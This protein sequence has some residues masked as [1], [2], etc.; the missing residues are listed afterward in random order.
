[1]YNAP[2]TCVVTVHGVGF[3][4]PPSAGRAGYADQ[5]HAGLAAALG[6]GVRLSDD[7]RRASYQVGDSVPIRVSSEWPPDQPAPEKG[8]ERVGKWVAGPGGRSRSTAPRHVRQDRRA[9]VARVAR[10][11]GAADQGSVLIQIEAEMA[12]YVVRN[13]RRE[14]VRGFVEEVLLRL[15]A[16]DDVGHVVVNAHSHG[17]VPALAEIVRSQDAQPASPRD[18]QRR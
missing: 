15:L 17:T 16:R 6:S 2:I 5:L 13:E 18:S 8:V 10:R 9:L 1:V 11:P 12:A 4:Q 14:L 7:P 3:Q